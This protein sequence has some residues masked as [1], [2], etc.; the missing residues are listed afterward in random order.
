[1]GWGVVFFGGG[2]CVGS[3]LYGHIHTFSMFLYVIM[4][5]FAKYLF[6]LFY[7]CPICL[8]YCL[9]YLFIYLNI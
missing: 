8:D 7:L 9:L 5:R 6:I 2:G 4:V 3:H 1:M